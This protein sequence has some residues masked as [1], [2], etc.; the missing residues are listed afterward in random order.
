MSIPTIRHVCSL[1]SVCQSSRL[2]QDIGLKRESYPFDWIFS[3]PINIERILDD[4]FFQFLN[5]EQFVGIGPEQCSHSVYGDSMFNH[6]N[7][8]D[9]EAHYLYFTRCVRRFRALLGRRDASKLFVMTFPNL[10]CG[11]IAPIEAHVANLSVYLSSKTCNFRMF[12][13]LHVPRCD[14]FHA[15]VVDASNIRFVTI[16]TVSVSNGVTLTDPH[17]NLMLH[18]ILLES[19]HFEV[20]KLDDEE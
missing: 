19:Y 20:E 10:E 8:K 7:P 6:H 14:S 17:E 9:N 1:G 4:D 2:L 5:R 16:R 15:S 11:T 13:I 18:R 12:V 3:N